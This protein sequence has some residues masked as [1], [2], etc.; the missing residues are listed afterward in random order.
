MSDTTYIKENTKFGFCP[1]CGHDS[2]LKRINESII[3]MGWTRENTVLVT[4]IGCVGLSDQ[5]FRMSAFHGLHG[6]SITYATGLKLANPELNIVVLI[7]DGGIGIG[8]NHYINAARRNVG[9]NVIIFN[10]FNFGMTGG[11]HSIT[12]PNGGKTLTT[13]D[14]N[15]EFP[16]DIAALAMVGQPNFVARTMVFDKNFPDIIKAAFKTPGFAAVDVWEF[17]TAHYVPK[18][19]LNRSGLND[20]LESYQFKTGILMENNRPELADQHL[21]KIANAK[22]T[23]RKETYLKKEFDHALE[24]NIKVVFAGGAGQKIKS[25]VTMLGTAAVRCGLYVTQKNDYPI[26]IMTGHSVSEMIISKDAINYT[27]FEKPDYLYIIDPEGLKKVGHFLDK[28]TSED[29][30]VV[31]EGID[32]PTTKGRVVKMPLKEMAKS[33]NRFSLGMISVGSFLKESNIMKREVIEDTVDK[34]QKTAIAEISKQSIA[35]IFEK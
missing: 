18:N 33:V 17:C 14:G 23:P 20:I 15:S 27:A 25:A 30:V 1:G 13:P 2:I 3:S 22:D 35:K 8:G 4:D 12:T 21:E 19:Q 24:D 9:I 11:S 34:F 16:M 6:R 29:T 5:Y 28:M 26:T 31:D 32:L 7:G 10:N